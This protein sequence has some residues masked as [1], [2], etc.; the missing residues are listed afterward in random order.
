MDRR[1][2]LNFIHIVYSFVVVSGAQASQSPIVE[3][4]LA[5]EMTI[6]SWLLT[7]PLFSSREPNDLEVSKIDLG[8]R[9]SEIFT[10]IDKQGKGKK[11]IVKMTPYLFELRQSEFND[12]FLVDPDNASPELL[13]KGLNYKAL[14]TAKQL[15]YIPRI[16]K[17]L[18]SH[19]IQDSL[20]T[21]YF[22]LEEHAEGEMMSN[23]QTPAAY[24]AVGQSLGAFHFLL[25]KDRGVAFKEIKTWSHGD[26]HGG[27]LFYDQKTEK[28]TLID[29]AL[30]KT[31]ATYKDVLK[32]LDEIFISR[33]RDQRLWLESEFRVILAK[34]NFPDQ[35]Q[36]FALLKTFNWNETLGYQNIAGL[37][38][39]V[40]A[41]L[42]GYFSFVP[43]QMKEEV[44]FYF[45]RRCTEQAY[46]LMWLDKSQILDLHFFLE[47]KDILPESWIACMKGQFSISH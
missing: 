2:F 1:Y 15:K 7:I 12:S 36:A 45:Q 34:G 33:L 26:P 4:R 13:E 46:E 9:E 14:L 20:Q 28:V 40:N 10:V 3:Y 38:E 29:F 41:F 6:K 8:V 21:L 27:N 19:S 32:D 23:L 17:I 25:A 11:Y 24:F 39:R 43:E 18:A 5:P 31:D 37:F 16:P 35:E 30:L 42:T 44:L 22:I 47:W